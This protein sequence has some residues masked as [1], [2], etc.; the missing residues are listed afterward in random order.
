MRGPLERT[1]GALPPRANQERRCYTTGGFFGAIMT[2]FFVCAPHERTELRRRA[3]KNTEEEED[4]G[5][6]LRFSSG[7][8]AV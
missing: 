3:G 4:S 8:G 1:G 2:N 5:N 7:G 6:S